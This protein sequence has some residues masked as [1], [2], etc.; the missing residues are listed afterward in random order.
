MHSSPLPLNPLAD[1]KYQ[2]VKAILAY[3]GWG[4]SVYFSYG[5]GSPANRTQTVN[6]I[7]KL[8]DE[9]DLDGIDFE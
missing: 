6:A 2:G 4:G 3:G 8:V 7:L 1:H 9:Y 5:F